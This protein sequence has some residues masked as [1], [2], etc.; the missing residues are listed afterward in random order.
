MDLAAELCWMTEPR[1]TQPHGC[2]G[3][4]RLAFEP[5]ILAL[6]HAYS[7]SGRSERRLCRRFNG[8]GG[9]TDRTTG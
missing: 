5:A 7:R 8:A 6:D 1:Q 4:I 9:Y 3:G 2:S